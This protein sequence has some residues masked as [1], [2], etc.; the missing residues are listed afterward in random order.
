MLSGIN[1]IRMKSFIFLLL[2]IPFRTFSQDD[3]AVDS[4]VIKLNTQFYLE[5]IPNDSTDGYFK[6]HDSISGS[7]IAVRVKLTGKS[8]MGSVLEVFNPYPTAFSYKAYLYN[9]KKKKYVEANVYPVQPKMG[10]REMWDFPIEKVLI[11][12]FKIEKE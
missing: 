5:H 12:A 6:L 7:I 2:I 4:V 9:F 1:F 8:A 10:T 11:K 3:Q